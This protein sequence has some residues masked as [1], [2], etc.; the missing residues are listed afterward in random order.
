[1]SFKISKKQIKKL[2]TYLNG[3]DIKP[4]KKRVQRNRKRTSTDK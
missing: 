2:E 1:M 4:N 3:Q